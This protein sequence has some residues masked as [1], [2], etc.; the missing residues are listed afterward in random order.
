MIAT[1]R[2]CLTADER[3]VVPAASIDAKF[4]LCS[5]GQVIPERYVPL[6]QQYLASLKTGEV[7]SPAQEPDTEPTAGPEVPEPIKSR[8]KRIPRGM[9]FRTGYRSKSSEESPEV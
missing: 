6:V 1:L 9:R 2:L 8:Q 3:R 5:E 4:L 7:K